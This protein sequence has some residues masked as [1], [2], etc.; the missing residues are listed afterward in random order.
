MSL[1]DD[2]HGRWPEILVALGVDRDILD[3]KHHSCPICPPK[4]KDNTGKVRNKDRF[5]FSD[6]NKEGNYFCQQCGPGN[7]FELLMQLNNWEFTEAASQVSRVAKRDLPKVKTTQVSDVNYK[8]HLLR[9][10]RKLQPIQSGDPVDYYLKSRYLEPN[11]HLRIHPGDDLYEDGEVVGTYPVMAA[12]F[13][14]AD[15]TGLGYHRT[16]LLPDG[17]TRK[18]LGKGLAG[19]A[20]RLSPIAEEI[21]LAEGIET[22]LSV[23]KLL[24]LPCWAA[25]SLGNLKSFV[26]PEGVKRVRIFADSDDHFAGQLGAVQAAHDLKSRGVDVHLQPFLARGDWNDKLMEMKRYGAATRIQK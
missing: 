21:G 7:G 24:G 3:G 11:E 14:A 20:I 8:R 1:K 16:Y 26:P 19:A 18:V 6:Y 12:L 9:F 5:R 10:G 13:T 22:A 4:Y 25:Y 2:T 15:G 23:T 17:K